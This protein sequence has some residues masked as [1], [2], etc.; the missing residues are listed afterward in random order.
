MLVPTPV[1]YRSGKND[2]VNSMDHQTKKWNPNP[3]TMVGFA[4]FDAMGI[5]VLRE[6]TE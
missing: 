1:T 2:L 6:R 4:T 3:Q 5:P